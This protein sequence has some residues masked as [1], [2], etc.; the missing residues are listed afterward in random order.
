MKQTGIKSIAK[1]ITSQLSDHRYHLNHRL[2][3]KKILGSL[4]SVKGK[5]DQ[6]FIKLSN[7][8]A[9]DILGWRGYAPWLYVYSAVSES[10]KEG[11]IPDNYYGKVVV[12]AL[13]GDY[14]K[15]SNLKPLTNKLFR[16]DSG[17]T[18]RGNVF[19]DIAYYVNGLFI[20]NNDEVLCEEELNEFF[21][22][23]SETVVFKVDNSL[24]GRG[25]FFFDKS[26]FELEKV[27]FLGNGV[28]QDYIDQHKFF[29]QLMPV[30]VAT[31]RIT[32]IIDDK[33]NVSARACYLRI[34]RST[35]THVKS[36]SHIRIPVNLNNGELD[37]IGY[38]TTW[39]TI[40]RHPDTSIN[41]A[42]LRIPYF[43][44][45]VSTAS[46]LHKLMPYVR[47]IGW[48]MIVDKNN[49]IKI[50]EWNG[51][52]NDIKFS[53][54]TQGPCFSDLGWEKLWNQVKSEQ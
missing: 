23:N 41:F 4:E 28:F 45:C 47:C 3:A 35:D 53:E 2:Q 6:R 5:T 24:Q 17:I 43:H 31:L 29:E 11:W 46:E 19:P 48:D 37:T 27:R 36:A 22:S 33:G 25:V 34:G 15:V 12:P 20:S 44:D 38:L 18:F 14:G 1:T 42:K 52:H 54:A 10:F 16:S 39:L 8:Y 9:T 49:S 40:D 7:E 50:M 32:T 51:D 26:S 30:S 13:K 21:F